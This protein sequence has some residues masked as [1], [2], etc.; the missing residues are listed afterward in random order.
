M[1]FNLIIRILVYI[2]G[3]DTNGGFYSI[4]TMKSFMN[5]SQDIDNIQ[6]GNIVSTSF[7]DEN[8]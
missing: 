1:V 5:M 2:N 8:K 6:K 7:K 4:C 3:L